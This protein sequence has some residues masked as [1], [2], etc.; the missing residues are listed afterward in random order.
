MSLI[1]RFIGPIT[2]TTPPGLRRSA[3]RKLNLVFITSNLD[4]D[5]R[6]QHVI[7]KRF[8]TQS[9]QQS[10]MI[11]NNQTNEQIK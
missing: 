11:Q 2:Y 1:L 10:K 5:L 6:T 9:K 4:L 7:P 8:K 3:A